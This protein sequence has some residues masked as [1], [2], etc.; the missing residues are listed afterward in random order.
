MVATAG[1]RAHHP[2]WRS[3][4]AGNLGGWQV[5]RTLFLLNA[6]LGAVGDAGRHVSRTRGTSSCRARS[7]RRRTPRRGT[8]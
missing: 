2:H 5:A 1:P 4:A 7:T 3:A 6:L 8:S